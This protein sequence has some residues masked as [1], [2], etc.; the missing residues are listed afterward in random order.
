MEIKK[1]L[2][3]QTATFKNTIN[4][5]KDSASSINSET[6]NQEEPTEDS[7]DL[8][9]CDNTTLSILPCNLLEKG[10]PNDVS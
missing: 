10:N 7:V 1:S 8:A 3:K 5:I 6:G 9:N 2:L 4:T